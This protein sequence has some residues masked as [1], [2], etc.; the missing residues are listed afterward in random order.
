MA[1]LFN[2]EVIEFYRKSFTEIVNMSTE[3][4]THQYLSEF[5]RERA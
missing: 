2:D 5:H 4:I 3:D 1:D